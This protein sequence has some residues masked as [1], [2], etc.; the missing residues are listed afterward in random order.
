M[1]VDN[2]TAKIPELPDP[3]PEDIYQ[4]QVTDVTMDIQTSPFTG[5]QGE[6]LTWYLHI[7]DEGEYRG[8]QILAWTANKWFV[9]PKTGIK[10]TLFALAEGV[11]GGYGTKV[12]M[13]FGVSFNPN[14]LIGKQ[15]RITVKQLDKGNGKT[16]PKIAGYM[17]IKKELPKV[18]AEVVPFGSKKQ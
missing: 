17:P 12:D 2:F 4:V 7:L 11:F 14:D 10:S 15:V 6:R 16:T 18:D 3:L 5:E 9:N 8:R 13:D 1:P